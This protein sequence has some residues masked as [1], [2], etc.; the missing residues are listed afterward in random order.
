MTVPHGLC[1][2]VIVDA[3]WLGTGGES[4]GQDGGSPA[5]GT[6]H[7]NFCPSQVITFTK[8]VEIDENLFVVLKYVPFYSY[9]LLKIA[10]VPNKKAIK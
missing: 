8:L 10:H 9:N 1:Y 4:S 6:D 2:A 7:C 5:T 3:D